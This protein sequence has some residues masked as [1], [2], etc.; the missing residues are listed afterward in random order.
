MKQW[1]APW[2]EQL[3]L[4]LFALSSIASLAIV[5]AAIIITGQP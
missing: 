4:V 2:T 3:G 5:G 1:L